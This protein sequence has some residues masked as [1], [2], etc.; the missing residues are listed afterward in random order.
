MRIGI[1][2]EI[3]DNEYR[4]GIVLSGVEELVHQGHEVLIQAGAGEGSVISDEEFKEAGASI[5][6][7]AAALWKNSELIMKVKEPLP[8]EYDLM[9]KE[10]LLLPFSTSLL[11]RTW[12]TSLS[13][14][15]SALSPTKLYRL[16]ME[17]SLFLPP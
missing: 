5:L 13:N 4:V 2:T 12:W 3:K 16:P 6:P 9:T 17:V 10:Q 15:G 7:D 8:S 1:P 14:A 11:F